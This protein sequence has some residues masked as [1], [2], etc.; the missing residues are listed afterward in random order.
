MKAKGLIIRRTAIIAFIAVC[1]VFAGYIYF[2][3]PLENDLYGGILFHSKTKFHCPSCGL[4]RAVYCLMKFDFKLAFYYHAFFVCTLPF[5]AY[6]LLTLC[7]N[8]FFNKKIIPYPKHY[9]I[10][11][12]AY[13]G[14]YVAFAIFRNFT[15]AIY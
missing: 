1:L 15:T 5:L 9:Q 3:N 6:L 4:T 2:F 13:L 8:L 10:Y 14:L 7:V 11:L 12:Y